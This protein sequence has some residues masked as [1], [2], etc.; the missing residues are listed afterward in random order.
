MNFKNYIKALVEGKNIG[1]V[2]W[3]DGVEFKRMS[4]QSKMGPLR[5]LRDA[6]QCGTV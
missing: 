4:K 5:I 2:G 3:P 6:L 1:L